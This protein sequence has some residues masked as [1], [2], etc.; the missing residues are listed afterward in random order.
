MH[1]TLQV[2]HTATKQHV[3][4]LLIMAMVLFGITACAGP[5]QEVQLYDT[6]LRHY[7]QAL[8]WQDYDAVVS[9]HKNAY[10]ALTQEQRKQLRQFKVTS[11]REVSNVMDP[12]ERHATQLVEIKYYNTDYQI[13]H[14]LTL[15]NQWEYDTKSNHWY[16]L[17]PL[18]AFK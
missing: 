6:S 5:S 18:P 7:E 1:K 10:K 8:R 12:D 14:D 13:V 4:C 16:L 2:M 3:S 11:Y 17:N 9:F 15:K